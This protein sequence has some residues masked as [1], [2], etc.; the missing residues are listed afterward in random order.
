MAKTQLTGGAFQDAEGNVLANGYILMQVNQDEQ[1]NGTNGQLC[2]GVQIK[3]LLDSNG[4]VSQSPAQSV[5]PNDQ[6]TPSGSW[7]IVYVYS[8]AGQLVWGPWYVTVPT[9]GGTYNVS[10]WVPGQTLGGAP[11]GS[12]LL[13]TNEVNNG[14][15]SLLDLHAGSNITLTDNGSGRITI[16]SSGG[17]GSIPL[18]MSQEPEWPPSSPSAID[19]EFTAASL[20]PS[21][22]W[23]NQSTS[24]AV[25]T[26]NQQSRVLIDH[27]GIVSAGTDWALIVKSAPA[28]PYQVFAKWWY[29]PSATT[30]FTFV[31]MI[32]RDSGTGKFMTFHLDS[33][34]TLNI[35]TYNDPNTYGGTTYFSQALDS[36]TF[37]WNLWHKGMPL[38]TSIYDDG[39]QLWFM[40]SF[41]EGYSYK[42]CAQLSRT[43]FLANPNQVGLGS[44]TQA[45]ATQCGMSVDFFRSI[46]H[47]PIALIKQ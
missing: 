9:N 22:T 46:P 15:Q 27:P 14:S 41:D 31:G 8:A 25:A 34:F 44:G 3:I 11:V 12:I 42:L 19:D 10:N 36:A 5:W 20:D 18:G 32:I 13:Q 16:A 6:L 43:A 45:S 21:W 1:I 30:N 4:N 17:G 7:Y 29:I 23:I 47:T 39:N 24:I 33:T 26:M 40:I 2:A 35:A 37:P 38:Y 28:T